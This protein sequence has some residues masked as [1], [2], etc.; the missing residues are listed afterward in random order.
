[1]NWCHKLETYLH[2]EGADLS[3]PDVVAFAA[4]YF[5]DAALNWYRIH[6]REVELHHKPDFAYWAEFKQAFISQFTPID[7]EVDARERL[8]RLT[9]NKSVLSYASDFNALMLELPHMDESDRI[10]R[11]T[12]GLRP[13]I[14]I[15][16]KLHNPRTLHDAVEIAIRTDSVMWD[17]R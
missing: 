9:Q 4:A 16:V 8:A 14:R 17:S 12:N 13:Q 5:K 1:M 3:R 6:V 15:Q 7:P 2:G 11:F 10:W